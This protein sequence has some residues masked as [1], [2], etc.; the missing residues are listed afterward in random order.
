MATCTKQEAGCSLDCLKSSEVEEA[1]RDVEWS[2][3]CTA[4]KA[5]A[6][7][8]ESVVSK[9]GCGASDVAIT[10]ACEV[11]FL[12]PEDPFAE[13]CAEAFIEECPTILSWIE[14]KIFSPEK[15]CRLAE[16]C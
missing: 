4:C 13:I 2:L 9:M 11:I 6:G 10:A 16:L 14:G 5:G 8:I 3:E 12:G 7:K 1:P 15:A